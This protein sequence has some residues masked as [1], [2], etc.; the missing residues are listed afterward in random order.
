M[1]EWTE[2]AN[3]NF[4]YLTDDDGVMTVFQRRDGSW[5]GVH[6]DLF[7]TET[8]DRARDAMAAMERAVLNGVPGLLTPIR[9]QARP[10][11]DWKATRTGGW[12][13]QSHGRQASVKQAKSGKWY[14]IIGTELV[15]SLWFD[16]ADAAKT[17]ADNT[18]RLG[19]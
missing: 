15:P 16:S 13:R 7:T 1:N 17:F 6:A 19:T 9:R 18:G 11:S 14:V 2:N 10:V 3:G 12:F 4:V 5:A 8:F